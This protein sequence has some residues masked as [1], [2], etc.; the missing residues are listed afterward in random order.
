[1]AK[2]PIAKTSELK[3]LRSLR[4]ALGLDNMQVGRAHADAASS[5][6]RDVTRF[7]SSDEL[8]D[9]GHPDR[10]SLDKLLFLT[11]RALRMGGETDEAFTF[12]F[13]RVVLFQQFSYLVFKLVVLLRLV[14]LLISASLVLCQH[15]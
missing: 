8:E 7:T 4:A 3:E 12:E 11:E 10:V 15:Y 5:F 14:C 1:M 9:E 13:S 2:E 6:Y